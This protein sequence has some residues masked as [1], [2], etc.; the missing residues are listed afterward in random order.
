MPDEIR[1]ASV[2]DIPEG[3]MR[4]FELEGKPVAV[5]REDGQ[6]YAFENDCSHRHCTLDDGDLE[7]GRVVCACHGSAFDLESGNPGAPPATEPI[8]VY[9]VRLEGDDI[10]VTLE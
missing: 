6:I 9:P 3:E 8:P 2:N 5:A 7:D 10:F 1:I 4:A